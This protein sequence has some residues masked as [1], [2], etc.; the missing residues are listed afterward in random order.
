MTAAIDEKLAL[1]SAKADS[2][3]FVSECYDFLDAIAALDI[4]PEQWIAP[5]VLFIG[6]HPEAD[7]GM[8]GPL[9]DFLEQGFIKDPQ[10]SLYPEALLTALE[11]SSTPH[12][13]WMAERLCAGAVRDDLRER[14]T[15]YQ[16]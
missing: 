6:D 1:L 15:Q 7:F 11:R 13:R 14:F 3:F 10:H 12:L 16:G 8:P 4:R 2:D 5:L 9:V